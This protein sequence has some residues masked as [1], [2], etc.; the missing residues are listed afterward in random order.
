[1]PATGLPSGLFAG[2]IVI[3]QAR[4]DGIDAAFRQNVRT[5]KAVTSFPLRTTAVWF[6]I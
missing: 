5:G 6:A 2:S 1:L 3:E 4:G